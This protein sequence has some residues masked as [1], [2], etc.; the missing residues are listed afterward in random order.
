MPVYPGAIQSFTLRQPAKIKWF[1][2]RVKKYVLR[3][4]EWR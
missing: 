3:S 1:L 2:E 4:G